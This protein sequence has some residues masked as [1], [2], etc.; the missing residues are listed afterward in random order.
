[1][2]LCVSG[3]KNLSNIELQFYSVFLTVLS[4]TGTAKLIRSDR[5][6]DKHRVPLNSFSEVRFNSVLSAVM[7]VLIN[8]L[9]QSASGY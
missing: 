6:T 5:P 4:T 1:M 8:V 2:I 3:L 7:L 9:G